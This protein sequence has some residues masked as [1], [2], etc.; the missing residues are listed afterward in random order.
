MAVFKRGRFYH[1]EFVFAGRR[2][3]ESARTISKTV[4]VEAERKRRRELELAYNG[5]SSESRK[6]R[7][8]SVADA[9]AEYLDSY[10]PNHRPNSTV[11]V[12]GCLAHVRRLLGAKVV[13]DVNETVIRQYMKTRIGEG[14][15][16]RTVNAEIGELSR[17]LGKPWG[18]LWSKVRKLE[19]RKDVGKALTADQ[20][21]AL[22]D[23]IPSVRSPIIGTFVRVALLTAMRSGEIRTLTWGAGRYRAADNYCRPRQDRCWH[24]AA[25]PHERG[26][27]RGAHGARR[28][29]PVPHW[30]IDA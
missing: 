5:V 19:E 17:A 29:V 25:D 15:S 3:Q 9:V 2:I 10:A 6:A 13:A 21:R 24:G 30:G 16:G 7:V 8:R 14:A 23:A 20:E 27:V 22:L 11:F 28:L 12:K 1:Y 26:P 4:A 18:L